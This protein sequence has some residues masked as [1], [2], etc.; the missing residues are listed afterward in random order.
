MTDSS[1]A[2]SVCKTA[3]ESVTLNSLVFIL[4]PDD[5]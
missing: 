1:S 2:K 3:E 4:N 5:L